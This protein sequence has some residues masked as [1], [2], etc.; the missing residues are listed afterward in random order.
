MTSVVRSR[1]TEKSFKLRYVNL[2]FKKLNDL[3]LTSRIEI[4]LNEMR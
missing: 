2:L 4:K 1:S 3:K